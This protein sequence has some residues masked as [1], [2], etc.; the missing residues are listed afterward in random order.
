MIA[1]PIPVLG[2][3]A[4]GS[5]VGKTTLLTRLIPELAARG[6]RVSVVKH[7]HHA[8]D[9]DQ[10]G[11]D[12]YRI[13][14]A[15]AVQ[16]LIGSRSRWALMTELARI[17]PERE[18]PD[19]A[20]LLTQLDSRAADLVLVEGFRQEAIPKLEV[21][22]PALGHPLLADHDPYVIA[23]A[24]D[25]GAATRLPVLDLNKP[26]AIADFVLAWLGQ[27]RQPSDIAVSNP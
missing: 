20:E 27:L 22:R 23:V 24:S 3:C 17:A 9:I 12:S 1:C 6:L 10:P 2:C 15:G 13:R 5:G 7:A 26:Q 18:E 11:K 25:G 16:T 14:E 21:Y 4:W 8:F 19:L